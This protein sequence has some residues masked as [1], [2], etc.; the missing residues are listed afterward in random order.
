[1]TVRQY[2]NFDLLVEAAAEGRYR[3]RVVASPIGDTPVVPFAL[4]F[5]GAVL[6]NLLLRLD[7]GRSGTRRAADSRSDAGRQLGGGLFEAVF[8]EDV[9]LAWSRSRDAAQEEGK[10]LRLRL[11]L[12][13]AP[14][15]A[16]LPW[17][18]L[19]DKRTNTFISQSE[20]TPVVRYLD[21]AQRL[22]PLRV[23]GPLR[24]LVIVAS[25]TDL[26]ELDVDAEWR[27][28]KEALAERVAE[29]RVVVD[30]LPTPT[31]SELG[32]WLRHQDVHILHFVG[33]GDV[34][35]TIDEGVLYFCDA[36]GRGA[37]VTAS[38]LGAYVNDHDPLRLL[39]LNACRSASPEALEPLGGMAQRLVRQ[40]ASAVVAMQFP[41]TDK[42]A[43]TFTREFYGAVADGFPVDQAATYAR[44]A[45]LAGFGSEWATPVVFMRAADGRVFESVEAPAGAAPVPRPA[46]T[47]GAA[48]APSPP[49][50]AAPRPSR[51]AP[52]VGASA[53]A[54]TA[55]T[56]AAGATSAAPSPTAPI[57]P[58]AAP[59]ATT[60]AGTTAQAV[61]AAGTAPPAPGPRGH[62][63]P[64]PLAAASTMAETTAPAT[65]PEP[66]S[67]TGT[68]VRPGGQGFVPAQ[69]VT[70]EPRR[71]T[72]GPGG[73]ADDGEGAL[74][75]DVR[76][77]RRR[78]KPL[79]WVAA[80]VAA[81]LG[82]WLAVARPWIPA[83][84]PSTGGSV[85]TSP[86]G[87]G[88][89]QPANPDEGTTNQNPQPATTRSAEPAVTFDAV[90]MPNAPAIDGQ[91]GEWEGI[92][93]LS[94]DNRV[95]VR[96]EGTPPVSST[97]RLGW[98]DSSL[99]LFVTVDDQVITQTHVGNPAKLW[100]GDGVSF[101]FGPYTSTVSMKK[102][103]ADDIQV[104]IGP[105]EDD[106]EPVVG[107]NVASGSQIVP[108][109]D[110]DG[111]EAAVVVAQDQ[112]GYAVE[113]RVPW[114]A[115][116]VLQQ[117]TAGT[118]FVMNLNV[119]DAIASGAKRG[120]LAVMYS[121]NPARDNAN[122]ANR[123][124]WGQLTLVG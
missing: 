25:P 104:L 37:P 41:I 68:P 66:P 80:I 49:S 59:T 26:P 5:E 78:P 23:E 11:R 21:V 18:L 36:Y 4:P 101:E 82:I 6:E 112:S 71:P 7:P 100:N 33:H 40:N 17:E 110:V 64:P 53:A 119:S 122:A 75:Y 124:L 19:Y 120:N 90:R 117:P 121:N 42:A 102:L 30:L 85:E 62:A 114:S 86:S 92:P 99:Y 84:A 118:Q 61:P 93:T 9:A 109:S 44:K 94:S 31:V 51:P 2:E 55:A 14:G 97:W 3:A 20:R 8:A 76:R 103:N 15:I 106:T 29:G 43:A 28:V 27:G 32:H 87:E 35:R 95:A 88:S 105:R 96:A 54:A 91:G 50:A 10:G 81:T 79:L 46:P 48:P 47:E 56:A 13:D 16:G 73:R 34:D 22:R 38:V 58:T 70:H 65:L 123:Y 77:P 108:G 45:L 98:D 57:V 74:T 83:P 111:I 24:I 52:L 72:P 67:P 60:T 113:A 115:L 89:S 12:D 69:P 63:A 39:V 1:M 116:N 107:R